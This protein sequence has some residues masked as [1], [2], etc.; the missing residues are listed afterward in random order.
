[1][2]GSDVWIENEAG[3]GMIAPFEP[4]LVRKVEGVPVVSYGLSSYGYDIRLSKREFRVFRHK[5]GSV[6]DPKA[7]D[8][9]FLEGAELRSD[10]SGEF[11][12]VP[13][14]S[15][16]LGVAVE[17]LSIPL[18]VTAICVGKSTYARCGLIVNMT[19]VEAGWRGHLT[20]EISNSSKADCRVY[21]NE[22]IAQL[23]F[24]RGEPCK[25]TYDTRSGKY[26][27]QE[28]QIVVSRI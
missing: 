13:G 9:E 25:T 3:N 23:L 17:K 4:S 16:G 14:N 12:V 20:I 19:P 21:V 7:F 5:P 22:G 10:D 27:D 8:R 2:I 11:F 15:Y 24:F 6:I 18:D 28:E 1:M 26:Q